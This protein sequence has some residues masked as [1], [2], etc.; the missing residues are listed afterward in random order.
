MKKKPRFFC[1]NCGSEVDNGAKTC[2]GCGR[3]F[4]SVRCPSCGFS[5]DDKLFLKG[6]PSCGYS[7]SSLK[8]RQKPS[9]SPSANVYILPIIILLLII[10]FLSWFITR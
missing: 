4:S 9:G 3:F 10:A 1:D 7:D 8:N 2:P 5:G 6:C